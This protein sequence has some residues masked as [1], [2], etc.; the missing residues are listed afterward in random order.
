MYLVNFGSLN[1]LNFLDTITSRSRSRLPSTKFTTD[2]ITAVTD[3]LLFRVI[4]V[5][6]PEQDS[7]VK[8]YNDSLVKRCFI[9]NDVVLNFGITD[10]IK[11][12]INNETISDIKIE[13]KSRENPQL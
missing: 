10:F 8:W 2:N 13:I 3:D 1:G 12:V 11:L 4:R 6:G 5:H 9:A 7:I